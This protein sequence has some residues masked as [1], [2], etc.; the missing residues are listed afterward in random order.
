[1]ADDSN[2]RPFKGIIYR[3]QAVYGVPIKSINFIP[4]KNMVIDVTRSIPGMD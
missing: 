2:Y 4:E 3:T 1:M